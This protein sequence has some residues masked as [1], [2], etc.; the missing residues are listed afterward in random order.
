MRVAGDGR[1][2]TAVH[3]DVLG[4][5]DVVHLGSGTVAHPDGLRLGDLPVRRGTA[6]QMSTGECDEFGAA[7]LPAQEH[8]LF[9]GDEGVDVAPDRS[10][11]SRRYHGKP[12]LD[13]PVHL[14]RGGSDNS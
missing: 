7:R 13:C 6:G 1:P 9:V 14:G 3:I 5:V 11:D 2:V 8:L 12:P 4:A 10:V